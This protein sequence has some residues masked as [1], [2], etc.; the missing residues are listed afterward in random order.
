[1]ITQHTRRTVMTR[2]GA[3]VALVGVMAAAGCAPS[4]SDT[5]ATTSSVVPG[6]TPNLPAGD[7]SKGAANF[8]TSDQVSVQPVTF[9]NQYGMNVAGNL[10]VPNN[11]DRNTTNPSATTPRIAPVTTSTLTARNSASI[12]ARARSAAG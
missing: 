11:I 7:M 1:M 4:S 10:F 6:P 8:Y 9:K 5:A 2:I 12:M 3:G